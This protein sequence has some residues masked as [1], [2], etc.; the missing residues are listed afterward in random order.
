ME[1]CGQ[2]CRKMKWL[3]AEFRK[4]NHTRCYYEHFLFRTQRNCAHEKC[5][6]FEPLV[7]LDSTTCFCL[8]SGPLAYKL[9]PSPGSFYFIFSQNLFRQRLCNVWNCEVFDLWLGVS[10]WWNRTGWLGLKKQLSTYIC[11]PFV[12]GFL[13]WTRAVTSVLRFQ[14]SVFC[15]FVK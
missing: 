9:L 6:Y 1:F 2:Y 3:I 8:L 11:V 10:P 14:N 4:S 5:S 12:F 7:C 13:F 15:L